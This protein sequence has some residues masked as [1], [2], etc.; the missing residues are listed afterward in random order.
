MRVPQREDN[1]SAL[2]VGL[3]TDADHIHLPGKACGDSLN[4]V[5]RQRASQSMKGRLVVR[6]PLGHQILALEL[7]TNPFGN[8]SLE[9]TLRA[10]YLKFAGMNSYRDA[11]GN[12]NRFSSN[13]RHKFISDFR[14]STAD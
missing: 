14:F 7:E 12:R 11:F 8:G 3:V 9:H 5:I 1:F 4:R 13:T 6:G 2:H 10:L